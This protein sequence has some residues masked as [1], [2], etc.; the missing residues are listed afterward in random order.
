MAEPDVLTGGV[1]VEKEVATVDHGVEEETGDV[2]LE[3]LLLGVG[4]LGGS[5]GLGVEGVF[6]VA[7]WVDIEVRLVHGTVLVAVEEGGEGVL[8]FGF[9]A[10]FRDEDSLA[11]EVDEGVFALGRV[12]EQEIEV[13]SL[14]HNIL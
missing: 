13:H 11:P 2:F 3:M 12:E 4:C 9:F 8:L 7:E 14:F 5:F 10:G 1:E 6:V